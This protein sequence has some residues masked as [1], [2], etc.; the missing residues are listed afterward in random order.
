MWT[1]KLVRQLILLAIVLLA[2]QTD[3]G[4]LALLGALGLFVLQALVISLRA[5]CRPRVEPDE[6]SRD[7]PKSW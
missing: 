4:R 6:P 3:V 7:F 2:M 5:M 1:Q